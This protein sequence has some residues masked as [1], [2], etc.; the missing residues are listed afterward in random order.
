MKYGESTFDIL[1]LLFALISGVVILLRRRDRAGVLMGS[2]ALVLGGGDAFHLVPRVAN[3]FTDTDLTFWLGFGKLVTSLTMTL[4]Y[5][6]LFVLHKSL[7]SSKTRSVMGV[8]VYALALIR[9]IVCLFPQNNW[10]TNDSDMLWGIIR[11]IPFTV[12]G[13]LIIL[14]FWQTRRD[15]KELSRLWI[16]ITFSFLFYIPVAV[17]AG[18]VPLLGMLMLP[19]TVCYV[20]MIISFLRFSFNEKQK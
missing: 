19:K 6:L 11:N 3:Y 14:L 1:Y 9:A 20:L 7:F 2:A 17:G 8:S 10:F 15:N 5:V 12:L 13:L 16:Y 4:F 18:V